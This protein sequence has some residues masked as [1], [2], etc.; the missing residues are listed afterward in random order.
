[1]VGKQVG[2]RVN[3]RRASFAGMMALA[4]LLMPQVARKDITIIR[5]G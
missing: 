2:F 1:M 5:C 4:V 3:R